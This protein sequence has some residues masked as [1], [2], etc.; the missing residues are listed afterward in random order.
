V[1]V[2]GLL[3]FALVT[4]ATNVIPAREDL[5]ATRTML[6]EQLRENDAAAR[7]AREVDAY[8][9]ALATDPWAVQRAVREE[10][11]RTD[12]DEVIVR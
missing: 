5:R 6:E 10:L 12:E 1:L 2:I 4:L 7:R 3:L 9:E 8:A 11:N